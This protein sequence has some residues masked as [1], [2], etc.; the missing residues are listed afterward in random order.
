[1]KKRISSRALSAACA[2]A[3]ALAMLVTGVFAWAD[4]S[5]HKS[6]VVTAGSE[7]A[8]QDVVL[9]EDFEE[10]TDWK[11]GDSLKKEI[12]VEN[13]GEGR[14]YVRLQLKEYMDIA[15][16][17]YD[18]SDEYLLLDGDGRFI[19]SETKAGL[20]AW[21]SENYPALSYFDSQIVALKA[22]GDSEEKYYLQTDDITNINGKYGKKLLEDFEQGEPE[23]LVDG[24]VRGGY[25]ETDDHQSHPTSECNY[26]KHL[27][28]DDFEDP[29]REYVDWT[30]GENWI[31]LTDWIADGAQP[32]GG[33]ILDDTSNEGWAYWGD[34]LRSGEET[35]LLLESIELIKQPEGPF[36]YALHVDMQASDVYELES[37][38]VG[39]PDEI[40][41]MYMA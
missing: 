6:N 21:L 35:T 10:P 28:M 25:E 8:M 5:Q 34:V 2:G 31:T 19:C 23:P 24:A 26:F 11:K 36:Y 15:K 38:F 14:I 22:Y 33:W 3:V 18:Y 20:K 1:M 12:W 13:T 39:M 27:W 7:Y 9:V 32:Y 40:K 17:K 16:M 30:L 4:S 37:K 41:D 29:F